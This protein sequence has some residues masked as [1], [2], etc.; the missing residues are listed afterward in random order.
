MELHD[1]LDFIVLLSMILSFS[2]IFEMLLSA[3]VHLSLY[4][5]SNKSK[6]IFLALFRYPI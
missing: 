1:Y 4:S 6:L 5:S 3:I 2:S